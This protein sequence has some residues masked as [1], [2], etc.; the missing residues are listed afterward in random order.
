MRRP[1]TAAALGLALL[2]LG[3]GLIDTSDPFEP[4]HLFVVDSSDIVREFEGSGVGVPDLLTG[5]NP[6]TGLTAGRDLAFGPEGGL[7]VSDWALDRVLIYGAVGGAPLATLGADAALE[8][9][10]AL[11]FDALGR[12]LVSSDASDSVLRFERDGSFDIELAA[13]AGLA[14]PRGMALG[15]TGH[16]FVSST[17]NDRVI[18]YSIDDL[19]LSRIDTDL[20]EPWGL[21]FDNA[22]RL[23]VANHGA[24]EIA[25]FEAGELVDT[26][27]EITELVS[28]TDL[29]LGP[30]GNLWVAARGSDLMLVLD[31][32]DGSLLRTVGAGAQLDGP[33][34]F[35][36]SPFVM[37]ANLKGNLALPGQKFGKLKSKAR[38]S[39]APGSRTASLLFVDEGDD[40]V[41][42]FGSD[43]WFFRGF[44]ASENND[45]KQ[46]SFVGSQLLGGAQGAGLG[47]L[48]LEF[49]GGVDELGFYA[50]K[51]GSGE[52]HRSSPD[53]AADA[54]V[55]LT[56]KLP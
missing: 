42:T 3:A 34:G 47:A 44:S 2:S 40:L 48:G 14:N 21:A 12:L 29:A 37:G 49:N 54:S 30:D 17:G 52:L 35:A 38:L 15:P 31:I 23:Y 7:Y 4:N 50:P 16:L 41:D 55:K 56:K 18:E 11:L 22:G 20:D 6:L 39:W 36:F 25:V 46:R 32:N 8:D 33:V 13:S 5:L 1:F 53:G 26:F 10:S 45:D 24:D 28:P 19:E 43:A 9:P 51:K 27:G